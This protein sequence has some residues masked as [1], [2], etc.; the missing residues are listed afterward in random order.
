MLSARQLLLMCRARDRAIGIAKAPFGTVLF[1]PAPDF[2]RRVLRCVSHIGLSC[3]V[4]FDPT[5]QR[6]VPWCCSLPHAANM[7][8]ARIALLDQLPQFWS[9]RVLAVARPNSSE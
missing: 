4:A 7:P 5:C 2:R 8:S 6:N 1:L 9:A 3:D